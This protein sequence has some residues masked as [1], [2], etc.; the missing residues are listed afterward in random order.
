MGDGLVE[1]MNRSLLNFLRTFVQNEGDWE[2]HLQLL[3]YIYRTT[4]HSSTGLSPYEILFGQNP[5]SLHFPNF[6]ATAILDPGEYHHQLQKKLLELRELVDF[7]I[8]QSAERQQLSYNGTK[9]PQLN[10]GPR[11]LLSNPTKGKLD[12]RWTGPWVVEQYDNSTTVKLR[13]DN[14]K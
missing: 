11:V 14:K 2:Q 8:V 9:P 5:P 3:L 13:K 6:P 7:S 10:Q 1:R 12:P 4:K